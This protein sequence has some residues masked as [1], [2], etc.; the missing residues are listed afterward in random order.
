MRVERHAFARL[1]AAVTKAVETKNTIPVLATVRL[2]AADGKL[3]ATATDLDV[4]IQSSIEAEGDIAVCVDARLLAGIVAKVSGD[5]VDVDVTETETTLKAGRSKFKLETL[6]VEDFPTLDHGKF[7]VSFETDLSV[8]VKPVAFAMSTELT[9]FY[10]CGAYLASRDGRLEVCATDGA[11]LATIKG[12][13]APEFDAIIIPRKAVG[14]IPD[15]AITLSLSAAKIRFTTG[16]TTI[17]SRLIEGTYP[18]YERVIPKS[19]D[20][21]VTFDGAALRA[22]AGRVAL[23]SIERAKGVKLTV[24]DAEIA[25]WGRGAGEASDAVAAEYEGESVEVGLNSAFLA[26]TLSNMPDGQA[27][28]AIADGGSPVLFTSAAAPDL[29]MVCMPMRVY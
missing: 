23:I 19:N 1:L 12:G 6:P 21:I 26:E 9:R 13:E 3:T 20:K 7:T 2:I 16:S 28:M 4:E 17:T 11:R 5:F 8:I 27:T 15:G 10:L 29:R 25:L 18:D 22:A 24:A 14:L